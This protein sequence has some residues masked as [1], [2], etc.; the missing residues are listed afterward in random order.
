MVYAIDKSDT[1][2]QVKPWINMAKNKANRPNV[3]VRL[4]GTR[5]DQE[6]YRE[7]EA[8]KAS[9]IAA[10]YNVEYWETASN[11][12]NLDKIKEYVDKITNELVKIKEHLKSV[13][14][15]RG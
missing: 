7:V 13:G 4:I 14:V 10:G 15:E 1:F 9:A 5:L 11:A 8:R 2:D 3:T 6:Q 12:A